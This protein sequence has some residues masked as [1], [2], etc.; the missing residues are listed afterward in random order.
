MEI[1]DNQTRKKKSKLALLSIN[2]EIAKIV[3][4]NKDILMAYDGRSLYPS[5]IVDKDRY[6]P[7]IETG[8]LFTPDKKQNF[9]NEC[10]NRAFTQ[11]RDQ[12]S[13]ILRVRFYN[14]QNLIFQHLHVEHVFFWMEKDEKILIGYEMDI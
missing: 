6:Y 7:R 12:A 3:N 2:Q 10:K 8:Y 1:I 9:I 14:P 11:F 4:K 5:A 13:F